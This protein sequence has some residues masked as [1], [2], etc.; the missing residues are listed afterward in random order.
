MAG[1]VSMLAAAWC[2]AVEVQAPKEP[3]KPTGPADRPP[4]WQRVLTGELA[5]SV[6]D[7][8]KQIEEFEKQGRFADAIPPAEEV[9][10]I[11]LRAQGEDH[12]QAVEARIHQQTCV[13]ASALPREDQTA[14]AA[15]IAQT[16]HVGE[17][18]DRRR[19]QE[20]EPLVRKALG[21]RRKLLGEEHFDTAIE[22]TNLA[23][24]LMNQQNLKDA[25]ALCRTALRIKLLTVGE[26]NPSTANGYSE[27]SQ[28][29]A[30]QGRY[31]EAEPLMRKAAR[32]DHHVL[33][34]DH[35]DTARCYNNLAFQLNEDGRF[36]EA[37][38][39]LRKA[40][41]TKLR[42][43]GEWNASTAASYNNLAHNLDARER[44]TEAE[45]LHRK[46]VE[47][48]VRIM[49]ENDDRTALSSHNLALNLARQGRFAEAETQFH[50]ALNMFQRI[51]GE[52][53]VEVSRVYNSLSDVLK[54]QGRFDEAATIDQKSLRIQRRELGEAHPLL[55][56]TYQ[57]IADIM[58]SQGRLA[59]AYPL[60][61]KSLNIYLQSWG[62]QHILT[63]RAYRDLA[64][65]LNARG[66]YA[67]AEEMAAKSAR[68]FET[69]RLQMS[70]LGLERSYWADGLPLTVLA[71]VEARRGRGREAWAAW[72]ATLARG[73]FDDLTTRNSRPLTPDERR[74]HEDLVGQLNRLGNRIAVLTNARVSPE[75]RQRGL[76]T[77]REQH[78]IVQRE[79]SQ[80]ETELVKKYKAAAGQVYTLEQVQA[81]LPSDAALVGWLDL[82]TQPKAADPRGD[83]WACVVR[84]SGA[85]ICVRIEGT[86][87]D[88]VWTEADDGRPG[89]VRQMLSKGAAPAWEKPL[90]ALAE[91]RLGPLDPALRARADLPAV[92]HLI[93]LPSPVL[94]GIPVEALLEARSKESPRYVVSYA[95]S[96]TMFAW[97]EERRRED[98]DK[99]AAPRRLLAL[100]DPVP[101][102]AEPQENQAPRPPDHGL[103]VRAVQP[104]SNAAGAGIQPGDVLLSYAGTRLA[105]RDDLTKQVQAADPKLAGIAAVVWREG[106][107]LDLTLK[108]GLLG[109]GLET[110][111][112]AQVILAQREGDALLRR[113]R[114]AR[115]DRLPGTRREVQ[116]IAA[117]FDHKDV[118]LGSDA[119]EQLLDDLRAR[120]QLKQFSVIHLAAHG[121]M[122]DLIPMN[123]QLLLSQD[124]LPDPTAPLPL[125]RLVYDGVLT[126]S[127]VMSTWKLDADLVVLSACQSGL[128]RS[129][130]GEGFIGFAQALFLA[131]GR[132]LVLSLWEVDDRATSLLMTRFYQNW[133]GKREGLDRPMSRAEA[134][135]EAKEWLRGL[136]A[137]QVASELQQMPRG[138]PRAKEGRPVE[139]H[140]FASPH[141]WAAFML[142]GDPS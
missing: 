43:L 38:P 5:K 112:P 110:K 47:I 10:K 95:P 25:E 14:L 139:G 18:F 101:A 92:N 11:R 32:I 76:D 114:G 104:G 7:L 41:A 75:V 94:A 120:D 109:L 98:R 73:L 51:R 121:K 44:F 1:C 106:K 16:Q 56:R 102:P 59:D 108:P 60:Y 66:R 84:H 96:G 63:A 15:V 37:E 52:E 68:S 19:F 99:P 6:Q 50:N 129:S 127:E 24:A 71:A 128:G 46:T 61:E 48:C 141:Y 4:P 21:V 36:G 107:T 115:F 97:L 22:Y 79:L 31:R 137:D 53:S 85:P 54:R 30:R 77:F 119:S 124:R 142:T 39:L 27:L 113:P 82:K 111:P 123:S 3:E 35:P 133:L 20:V 93:V 45:L 23:S 125:D 34:D 105:N 103:L 67:D 134:L 70:S 81:Q 138:Q 132:S 130:G 65:N 2:G 140:P 126:A 118:F 90:A 29:L 86:G 91:Q 88:R 80:L 40:L 12:W 55:A 49:G 87:P 78:L 72:E 117:L 89:Q 9:L 83:H 64:G 135:R 17:L 58:T 57:S 74:R 13:R 116:A 62:E 100:G 69:A 122:D 26:E 33:G 136:T 131:G 42:T 28:V 8:E